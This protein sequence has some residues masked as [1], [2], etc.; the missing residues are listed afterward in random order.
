ML[1][2]RKLNELASEFKA[3][4]KELTEYESLRLAIE[5]QRNQ[6]LQQAFVIHSEDKHPTGLEAIAIAL[7]YKQESL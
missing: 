6:I 7:G 3:Q 5:L 2:N 1:I 4:H